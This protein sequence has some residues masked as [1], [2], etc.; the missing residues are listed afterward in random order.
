MT[1]SKKE[2]PK[3]VKIPRGRKRP[4]AIRLDDLLPKQDVTGG[5]G[6]PAILFGQ[7]EKGN[8]GPKGT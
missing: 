2:T 5:S 8:L 3:S 1:S 4:K 6:R 7:V